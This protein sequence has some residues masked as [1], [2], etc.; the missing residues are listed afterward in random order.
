MKAGFESYLEYRHTNWELI[1][2]VDTMIKKRTTSFLKL[3]K[4]KR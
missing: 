4:L 1:E 2:L 3:R